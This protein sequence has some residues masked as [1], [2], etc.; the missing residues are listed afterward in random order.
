[1]QHKCSNKHVTQLTMRM[2]NLV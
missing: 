1:M 2:R